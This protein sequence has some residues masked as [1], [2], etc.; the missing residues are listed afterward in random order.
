MSN[1][2][3]PEI[4]KQVDSILYKLDAGGQVR[5]RLNGIGKIY[6]DRKVPFI[7][8]FRKSPSHLDSSAYKLITAEAS[9]FIV[10]N[11]E[12]DLKILRRVLRPIIEN[13]TKFFDGFFILE[14]FESSD[15]LTTQSSADLGLSKPVFR[16]HSYNKSGIDDTLSVL[17]ENL[18][19]IK[20]RRKTAEVQSIY[21]NNTWN[22]NNLSS[23]FSPS[24]LR[25]LK[26][27][28]VGLEIGQIYYNL[29]TGELY[30]QILRLLRRGLSRIFKRT[31]HSFVKTKTNQT[32]VSYLSL[33]RRMAVKAVWEIDEKL[34]QISGSFDLL[35]GVTP[36][37]V[38]QAWNR[39]RR[40]SYQEIPT[41][42]YR[43]LIIDPVLMKRILFEVPIEKIEDI[44]LE[45]LFR[46]KQIELD[47]QLT[48]LMD[49]RTLKF[50]YGGMQLYDGLDPKTIET[51]NNILNTLPPRSKAKSKS[52][53]LDADGFAE[54]ARKELEIY[55]QV[56]PELTANVQIRD[57]LFS[58]LMVSRGNLLVGSS[59]SVPQKRVRALINHEIG[60]HILT[61]Y[62]GKYQPFKN[63]YT[64]L[65][66]Y[67]EMQEGLAVLGEYLSGGL[68]VRRLRLLAAR[69]LAAQSMMEGA[70]FLEVFSLLYRTH[71]F[72]ARTAF[73]MTMRIFRGGGLIKDSVY[74]RGFI[75]ILEYIKNGGNLEILYI[76]K[77]AIK[78]IPIIKELRL[79]K[80]LK[81]MPLKPAFLDEEETTKRLANLH[82][83]IN[84]FKLVE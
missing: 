49:I 12:Q 77:I 37:N 59:L 64:G 51:A 13:S 73:I 38:E 27:F 48:L 18:K 74:L 71:S 31:F 29:D 42:Q 30:P 24:E 45:E 61:Y 23:I 72:N 2:I 78:H 76:G 36:V 50:K 20:I 47:R 62:N 69:V 5:K 66:G 28:S 9:Y 57:D 33:G 55:R 22:V 7:C 46:E 17:N 43:P 80:I 67:D 15:I 82:N 21:Y 75:K 53:K 14:V 56:Y 35:L 10:S 63:L 32:P 44:T 83:G 16:V 3:K 68:D 65:A 6:I 25:R 1:T 8:V 39:F 60:T 41:F 58:G 79:R 11:E 19:R 54:I 34:A 4:K 26:C 52:P 70:T 40:K 81:P 84:I